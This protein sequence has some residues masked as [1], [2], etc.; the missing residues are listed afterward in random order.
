MNFWLLRMFLSKC[1]PSKTPKWPPPTWSFAYT[2]ATA[3]LIELFSQV[4][5]RLQKLCADLFTRLKVL[6]HDDLLLKKR[7]SPLFSVVIWKK[8]QLIYSIY[9]WEVL[10][11]FIYT[12]FS[13]PWK[14]EALSDI[15]THPHY[16]LRELGKKVVKNVENMESS[17]LLH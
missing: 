8:W 1:L 3:W 10:Q 17:Q 9:S 6:L 2:S 4:F 7:C 12:S 14:K 5:C 15:Y 13:S 16:D 11:A